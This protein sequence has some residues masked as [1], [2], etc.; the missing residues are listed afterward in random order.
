[1]DQLGY[2]LAVRTALFLPDHGAHFLVQPLGF[3]A[4]AH[5]GFRPQGVC[6]YAVC[7]LPHPPCIAQRVEDSPA[8]FLV[9]LDRH[10][11]VLPALEKADAG[12]VV[13]CDAERIGSCYPLPLSNP[14]GKA[15]GICLGFGCWGFGDCCAGILRRGFCGGSFC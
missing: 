10:L 2:G 15:R 5:G 3:D 1:M 13:M 6:P 14:F 8:G 12:K 11:A 4:G 9:K 7:L